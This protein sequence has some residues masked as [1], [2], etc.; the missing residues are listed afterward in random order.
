M[1]VGAC[2]LPRTKAIHHARSRGFFFFLSDSDKS[3]VNGS[4]E[5]WQR[6]PQ[7]A[8]SE[9]PLMW[10]LARSVTLPSAAWSRN[11]GR[12]NAL[13]NVPS[14]RRVA[15]QWLCSER[16]LE[17]GRTLA[18]SDARKWKKNQQ[19][20]LLHLRKIQFELQSNEGDVQA[21]LRR[22]HFVAPKKIC[23]LLN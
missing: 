23:R 16:N 22:P 8:F 11:F 9:R 17:T 15:P 19:N 21:T 6:R 13:A 2:R 7:E 14:P 18:G 3:D 5:L 10:D 12:N 20:I 1:R 4:D